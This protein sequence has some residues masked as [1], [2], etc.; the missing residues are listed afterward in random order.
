M[1]TVGDAAPDFSLPSHDGSIVQ[2]RDLRGSRV[3]IWFFVEADTPGCRDEGC[4]FRDHQEY[5][6]E[7]G[8]QLLGVSFDP[9]ER[10]AAFAAKYGFAFPLLSDLDHSVALAYGAC[11]SLSAHQP[12]R[13]SLLV[14]AEGVVERVYEQVDPRDHA[15]RVLADILDL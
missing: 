9:V 12:S 8:I 3:L 2:L 4:G 6:D 1:L 11:D 13:L 7:G 5:L 14:D 15:A 10:N